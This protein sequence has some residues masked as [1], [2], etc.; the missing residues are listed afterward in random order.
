MDAQT[1]AG[2]LTYIFLIPV[3]GCLLPGTSSWTPLCKLWS[4]EDGNETVVKLLLKR[5]NFNP[6][7]VD[8]EYGR[9]LLLQAAGNG[10]GGVTKPLL[11]LDDVNPD[12]PVLNREAALRLVAS[13]GHTGVRYGKV[14]SSTSWN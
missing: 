11:E 7:T 9:T 2:V 10:R 13:C 3:S 12:I 5:E 8:T 1:I 4:T 6:N 14:G